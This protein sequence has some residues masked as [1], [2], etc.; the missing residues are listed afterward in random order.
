MSRHVDRLII[1]RGMARRP[2]ETFLLVLGLGL[3]IGASAAGIALVS[4]T[5]RDSNATL[6]SPQYREILVTTR[7]EAS[8]MDLPVV[9]Q[10]TSNRIALTSLDLTA[11]EDAPDVAYAYIK[12]PEQFPNLAMMI[13]RV[14]QAQASG[15]PAEIMSGDG[16]MMIAVAPPSGGGPGLE[17]SDETGTGPSESRAFE[18]ENT[19]PE[20]AV[21]ESGVPGR[22]IEGRPGPMIRNS[23]EAAPGA[24]PQGPGGP[25]PFDI[26]SIDLSGPQPVLERWS[27]YSVTPEFFSAWGLH[28][29]SGSLFTEEDIRS[30]GRVMV[31]GS[32]LAKILY[33]DG[34][35]IGRKP[36]TESGL[37]TIIG[38]LEPTG[39]ELDSRAFVPARMPELSGGI[40][41]NFS[42]PA[43]VRWNSTLSFMVEEATRLSEAAAQLASYFDRKYGEGSVV[44]SVPREE[45][46][47][48]RDRNSRMVTLILFLALA[49][50]FIAAVNVSNTL[51][52]RALRRQKSVGILKALGASKRRIFEL[53]FFESLVIGLGGAALGGVFS[54]LLSRLM[55]GAADLGIIGPIM[56]AI[57]TGVSWCIST[58]LTV[59]PSLQASRIPAAEAMRIE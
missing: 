28:A 19:A 43:R 21:P 11:A 7:E 10:N 36:I 12:N 38:V 47:A 54:L 49:G 37:R 13:D 53:F 16:G 27:G 44:I 56:L 17:R 29:E 14:R 8:E 6:S 58:V 3:G 24:G 15:R 2:V 40:N 52:S 22:V 59:F 39:T 5:I 33:E 4:R 23:A 32:E 9:R 35:A 20:G 41:E 50:L 31:L 30:G 55:Q 18:P 34:L 42:G 51:L 45:A 48:M 57:G 26:G 25:I 46:Q 1:S